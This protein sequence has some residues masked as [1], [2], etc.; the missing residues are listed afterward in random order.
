[1]NAPDCRRGEIW[2]LNF[3]PSRGSEQ[4]GVRPALIIQNDTGNLH[5]PTTIVAAITSTIRGYPFTVVVEK[6]EGGLK[7]QSTVNCAQILTVDKTRL[8]KKLGML[9]QE[10]MREVDQAI[11][12]SLALA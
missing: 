9:S 4:Q 2:Q 5:G 12:I 11:R 1:M 8:I 3:N 7:L 6:H 10:R